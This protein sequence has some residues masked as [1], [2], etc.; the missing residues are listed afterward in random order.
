MGEITTQQIGELAERL[1]HAELNVR[2]LAKITDDYPGL[3]LEQAYDV[4]WEIR[5]RKEERGSRIVG[6]KVGLTSRAKMSQMGVSEPIYGFLADYFHEPEGGEVDIGKLI[7]PKVEAEIAFYTKSDLWGP[8]CNTGQVLAATEFILPAVEIIDSRYEHFKFDLPSV[9]ADN[10]SSAR[11]V[12]GGCVAPAGKLD[13]RTL[14]VVLERNGRVAEVGAGAAVLNHPAASVALLVNMLAERGQHL[15]AG[16]VVLSGGITAA[17][18]VEPG[19]QVSMHAHGLGSFGFF[20]S[21]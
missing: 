1:E 13:L 14:G 16:S 20:F 12:T 5:R 9:I 11:F 2:A 17:V 4:Q 19:D 6:F 8:G 10:A 18:A 15:P 21:A 3:S 7:H